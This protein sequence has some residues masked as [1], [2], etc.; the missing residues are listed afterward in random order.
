MTSLDFQS[1]LKQEK[2]LR[3]AELIAKQRKNAAQ[4]HQEPSVNTPRTDGAGSSADRCGDA[5]QLSCTSPCVESK[6]ELA[7]D[8]AVRQK[9]PPLSFA[10]LADRL[11]LDMDK[12]SSSHPT[13]NFDTQVAG[14]LLLQW[15]FGYTAV[16]VSRLVRCLRM[17]RPV[18][19]TSAAVFVY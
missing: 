8:D 1:L 10:E 6:V 12:A 7:T 16:G 3:R 4:P 15:L 17:V 13:L 11:P 9:E 5:P 14:A 18:G 2:A 19:F